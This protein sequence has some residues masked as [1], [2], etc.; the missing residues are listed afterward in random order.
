MKYMK[1]RRKSAKNPIIEHEK[2]FKA[3]DS[4]RLYHRHLLLAHQIRM[5]GF[6]SYLCPFTQQSG[7]PCKYRTERCTNINQ[8]LKNCHLTEE[9][10]RV[11]V[12]CEIC[13]KA[14]R[15][16]AGLAY[17]KRKHHNEGEP[18][19]LCPHCG[20]GYWKPKDLSIHIEKI[21]TI[22]TLSCDLCPSVEDKS[23][24]LYNKQSLK[25]H[26]KYVHD[27]KHECPKCNFKVNERINLM[28][29]FRD[30]HLNYKQYVCR[31]CGAGF[32]KLFNARQHFQQVHL[33]NMDRKLDQEYFEKNKDVIE[34]KKYTDPNFPTYEVLSSVKSG[35]EEQQ[36]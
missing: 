14:Y 35:Y 1:I 7:E 17:H 21:H 36:V 8:H 18:T 34:N 28:E 5:K 4:Q 9:Y 19:H 32:A 29:H 23:K 16:S 3:S 26:K 13:G 25:D 22:P 31:T 30:K 20:K 11:T 10:D 15:D 33:K 2:I 24:K 27:K 6:K 12:T